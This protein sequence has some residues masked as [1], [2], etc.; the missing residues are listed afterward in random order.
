M[1]GRYSS[2]ENIL[3]LKWL[4]VKERIEYNIAKLA[5]KAMNYPGKFWPGYLPVNTKTHNRVLRSSSNGPTLE[6]PTINNTFEYSAANIFNNLPM[7]IRENYKLFYAER[8]FHRI[9]NV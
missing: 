9:C 2:T 8:A 4:P 1:L 3:D 7:Q 6:V 5:F